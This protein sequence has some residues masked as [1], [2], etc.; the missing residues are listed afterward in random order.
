MSALTH[1]VPR[2]L[3]VDNIQTSL[4]PYNLALR[5]TFLQRCS[6]FHVLAF[7]FVSEYDAAL[8]KIVRTHLHPDLVARQDLYVMH[9]HLPGYM[10]RN[11][12]SVLQLYPEH[13]VRKSFHNHA[14]LLYC[15]LFRHTRYD[16]LSFYPFCSVERRQD[17][18]SSFSREYGPLSH[19]RLSGLSPGH[20]ARKRFRNHDFL[21]YCP[22]FRLLYMIPLLSFLF[23]QTKTRCQ[24]SRD[25]WPPYA[26]NVPHTCRRKS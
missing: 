18:D 1:F 22:L 11:L 6:C 5:G 15:R 24:P 2:V 10:G 7:L 19:A 21:P 25:G 8:R 13:C 16:F 20:R 4:P 12:M 14:V 3:L 23:R 17:H 9:P 26:R